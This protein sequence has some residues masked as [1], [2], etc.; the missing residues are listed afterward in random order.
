MA[1]GDHRRR[2]RGAVAGRQPCSALPD[3][4]AANEFPGSQVGGQCRQAPGDVSPHRARITAGERLACRRSARPP[5]PPCLEPKL[6]GAHTADPWD[7]GPQRGGQPGQAMQRMPAA[8]GHDH[9]PVHPASSSALSRT[10]RSA[11]R[12]DWRARLQRRAVRDHRQR[13][14][15]RGGPGYPPG[16]VAGPSASGD[17]PAPRSRRGRR[18]SRLRRHGPAGR[19]GTCPRSTGA[20]RKA[21]PTFPVARCH[22]VDE[23][24]VEA[25]LRRVRCDW[26]AGGPVS[27]GRG[28]SSSRYLPRHIYIILELA[29]GMRHEH[30][31]AA[32]VKSGGCSAAF[33]CSA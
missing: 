8:R 2:L 26:S 1:G 24:N 12:R 18:M 15:P 31:N 22:P 6:P 11:S 19:T 33:S 20:V 14:R 10:A 5:R 17:L 29:R 25:G 32:C 28:A 9:R 21:S 30:R 13:G 27:V 3:V 4:G 7:T 23:R 16:Q